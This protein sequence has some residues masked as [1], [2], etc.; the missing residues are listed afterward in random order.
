MRVKPLI[1]AALVFAPLA[2]K[3]AP[4]SSA[5]TAQV[6]HVLNRLT[7]GPRPGD[8]EKVKSM[9]IQAFIDAQL[10]P[11]S[12][13]ES[14]VV[15]EQLQRSA[16]LLQAPSSQLLAQ[17]RQ[18]QMKLKELKKQKDRDEEPKK[19]LA[20][21]KIDGVSLNS[22]ETKDDSAEPNDLKKQLKQI[23]E[24]KKLFGLEVIGTKLVRA[25]DSPRQ[26]NEVM[27]DFWFNHFNICMTKG[28]DRILVGAYEEQ[29]IRPYVMGNFR[30]LL[31][32]TMHHPAM[33]FYLDNAQNT[34]DGFKPRNPKNKNTGI[35]ENYA[36]ELL[37]LHTLGVNGGYTQK[38]VME[39]ARV[40]TGWTMPIPRNLDGSNGY[41]AYFDARRHDFGDKVVLGKTIKGSGGD[42]IEQVLDMLAK[43]PST[44]HH[45]SYQLAQ[46]FV[47]D[48]PPESLVDKLSA[49]YTQTGGNIQ[50]VLRTLF[51]SSEFWDPKYENNK[52]KN[53]F[54]YAVSTLRATGMHAEQP[55]VLQQFLRIQGQP[56]Y[57]CLTPDGYKNTK[58]AW[59]NPDGLLKRIDF[60]TKMT[61]MQQRAS[62]IDE[63]S[64]V[65][66][67]N[68]GKLSEK[69]QKALEG[70]P[71][72]MRVAALL[73]SPEFM[74][75]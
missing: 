6:A 3:A 52:F 63:E 10:N 48:N 67:V 32:A 60:A 17:F 58:E 69:T 40:L 30:E 62:Q 1:L 16:N 24:L 39:L 20:G 19:Q 47:D 64:I 65:K 4:E 59:L 45:I 49:R 70:S 73:G 15:T 46:Y 9:G 43:H 71:P 33:M 72:N 21:A 14:S 36:R 75:Y 53:P 7:F 37:E 66:T 23:N 5:T 18:Q 56:I 13:P 55:M 29:A 50:A 38:D 11:K 68:G 35:N 74:R 12:I 54:H 8:E 28:V 34:K 31:G 57:G 61:R 22:E 51:A 27:T 2:A 42:E 25:V 44:A 41:W 26:L